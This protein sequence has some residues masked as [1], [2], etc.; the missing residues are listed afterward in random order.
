MQGNKQAS[1]QELGV[2]SRDGQRGKTSSFKFGKR[3]LCR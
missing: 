2:G 1:K 3:E